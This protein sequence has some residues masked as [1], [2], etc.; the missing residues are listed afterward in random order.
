MS[1]DEGSPDARGDS[2]LDRTLERYIKLTQE[3]PAQQQKRYLTP[4]GRLKRNLQPAVYMDSSAL[5]EF[6]SAAGAEDDDDE[7]RAGRTPLVQLHERRRIAYLREKART[8]SLKRSPT[9]VEARRA[10]REAEATLVCTPLGLYEAQEWFSAAVMQQQL[11]EAIGARDVGRKRPKDLG[12]VLKS[13]FADTRELPPRR[14]V[15]HIDPPPPATALLDTKLDP[16]E[17][18]PILSVDIQGFTWSV[19]DFWSELTW[20]MAYTQVGAADALHAC[21]ARHL[22][23]KYFCSFDKDYA[24]VEGELKDEWG[25]ELL[26]SPHDLLSFLKRHRHTQDAP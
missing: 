5:I 9:M 23:C 26:A 12:R 11:A 19:Q 15:W 18:R 4:T 7:C 14:D 10:A 21:F 13:I 17:L 2:D 22:R 24:R 3:T 16:F 25:I 8:T 20:L 6:F 1:G